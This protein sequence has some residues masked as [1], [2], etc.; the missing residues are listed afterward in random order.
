MNLRNITL[1]VLTI[2]S[3]DNHA[4]DQ[5][6][7]AMDQ[8]KIQIRLIK[9]YALLIEPDSCIQKKINCIEKIVQETLHLIENEIMPH[10]WQTYIESND[11]FKAISLVSELEEYPNRPTAT[12][13]S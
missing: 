9:K 6:L 2:M 10:R 5:L 3:L 7:Y 13:G 8:I 11:E 12:Y 4:S 1:A